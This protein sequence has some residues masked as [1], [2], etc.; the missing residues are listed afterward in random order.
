V[1]QGISASWL[2]NISLATACFN[3]HLRGVGGQKA[4][5]RLVFLLG[6]KHILISGSWAASSETVKAAKSQSGIYNPNP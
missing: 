1:T 6:T 2:L 3:S 4:A 5:H